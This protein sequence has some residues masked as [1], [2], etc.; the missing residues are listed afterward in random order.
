MALCYR[1]QPP[2]LPGGSSQP[3]TSYSR[4]RLEDAQRLAAA[5]FDQTKQRAA[6]L[7]LGAERREAEKVEAEERRIAQLE[8]TRLERSLAETLSRQAAQKEEERR[9]AA[10]LADASN[11]Q[12]V[13]ASAEVRN[14]KKRCQQ[15]RADQEQ[16]LHLLQCQLEEEQR[17]QEDRRRQLLEVE[18]YSRREIEHQEQ[19][20]RRALQMRQAR[21]DV[22]QQQDIQASSKMA[23]EELQRSEDRR[24]AEEASLRAKHQDVQAGRAKRARQLE[25][26]DYLAQLL[27]RR[28]QQQHQRQREEDESRQLGDEAPAGIP[29]LQDI[30]EARRRQ[31]H[32]A[33]QARQRMLEAL[34]C[35]LESRCLDQRRL[36]ALWE[37]LRQEE[38]LAERRRA[39][40][41]DLARRA[42][43]KR[44]QW[45]DYQRSILDLEKK[46]HL[47]REELERWR[48][49]E[50]ERLAVEAR[51]E[52]YNVERRRRLMLEQRQQVERA[53]QQR[54]QYQHEALELE[55]AEL[56][57]ARAAA[58][59]EAEVVA[60]ERAMLTQE[61]QEVTRQFW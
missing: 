45:E 53:L 41:R 54:E 4:P 52:Q 29:A 60:A 51:L 20:R 9:R 44:R 48:S 58:R 15:Q 19:L 42:E 46:N 1:L 3:T 50:L 13:N 32:E 12:A 49:K 27:Q 21:D 28:Q 7:R 30:A 26:Q 39:S 37:D 17:L 25:L 40:E 57:A 24:Q 10:K 6:T 56:E 18:D 5:R 2:I 59:R 23:E 14:L 43:M 35:D 36:E 22:L 47:Q 31:W 55:R 8:R 34:Y 61:H 38:F 33:E 11:F 16:A